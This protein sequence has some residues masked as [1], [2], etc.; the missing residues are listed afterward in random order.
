MLV[1]L[2]GC[3]AEGPVAPSTTPTLD[4]PSGELTTSAPQASQSWSKPAFKVIGPHMSV[5]IHNPKRGTRLVG[6]AC[7]RGQVFDIDSQVLGPE[8]HWKV[9]RLPAGETVELKAA[10]HCGHN[11][12]DAFFDLEAPKEPP[13]YGS[14]LLGAETE[15]FT[16][17]TPPPEPPDDPPDECTEKTPIPE[18]FR[19]CETDVASSPSCLPKPCCTWSW[20]LCDWECNELPPPPPPPPQCNV[21]DVET[22]CFTPPKPLGNP[23]NECAYFNMVPIGKKEYKWGKYKLARMTADVAIVKA[24]RTYNVYTRVE[25]YRTW[26]K[27]CANKDISH[28]TYCVCE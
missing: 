26:L 19:E 13:Y 9:V 2:W 18:G 8:N 23:T 28:I 12:C 24:G 1:L 16:C 5:T 21:D 6:L 20:E 17:N 3:S 25:K 15:F 14:K 4:M 27:S 22:G 10:L 11:Q 7:Y